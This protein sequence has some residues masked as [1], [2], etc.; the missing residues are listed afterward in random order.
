MAEGK[1]INSPVVIHR[2]EPNDYTSVEYAYLRFVCAGRGVTWELITQTLMQHAG[3]KID[4]LKIRTVEQTR[5]QVVTQ[6]E[7]Y[8]FDIHE[9][10]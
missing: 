10:C 2:M 4:Q 7:N 9:C 3:R 5:T 8:Y 6:T 1:S